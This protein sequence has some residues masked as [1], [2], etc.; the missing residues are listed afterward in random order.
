MLVSA[1][2]I[3]FLARLQMHRDVGAYVIMIRLAAAEFAKFLLFWLVSLSL[4]ASVTVIWFG[5]FH[6]YDSFGEALESLCLTSFGLKDMPTGISSDREG[7]FMFLHGAFVAINIIGFLSFLTAMMTQ[8]LVQSRSQLNSMQNGYFVERLPK[9]RYS[10][11]IGWI[12]TLPLVL[13]PFFL[14]FVYPCHLLV[15]K[16]S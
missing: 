12:A 7:G 6:G 13:T 15:E 16:I 4:F 5:E 1:W 2:W 11:Q 9:L 8:V 10:S 14:I 3:Y